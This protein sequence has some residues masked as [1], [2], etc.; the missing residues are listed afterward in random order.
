MQRLR[1]EIRTSRRVERVLGNLRVRPD[2]PERGGPYKKWQGSHW[3]LARLGDLGY[4]PGDPSLRAMADRVLEFWLTPHVFREFVP[5][6]VRPGQRGPGIPRIEGR[7]RHCASLQ[8]NALLFVTQLGLDDGRGAQLVDRLLHWQWPDGGWN[9][10]R[11]PSADTSAFAE[12]LVPMRGLAAYAG[13]HRSEP[14]RAAARSASEVFLRRRMFR[15]VTDG[16]VIWRD[17]VRLH[18][19]TYYHYD[20]LAGLRGI[21]EVGRIRDPRC[22]EALDL[23]EQKRL[24]DGG[25][26]AEAKYY[27][28]APHGMAARG[29]RVDWGGTSPRRM[30]PWVTVDALAVLRAAG[31]FAA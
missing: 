15:R 20:F 3:A 2:S 9:C 17:F 19:P 31:R 26:P 6:P 18:Y 8:G 14:A 4:P 13:V 7:Y 5:N 12:T 10:D 29:E 24:P 30:N 21:V 25:W 16:T 1:E 22:A 23:L 11:V 28:Y 27:L